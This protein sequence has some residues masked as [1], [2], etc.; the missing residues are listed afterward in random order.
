MGCGVGA[1]CVAGVAQAAS[2]I[3]IKEMTRVIFIHDFDSL[4]LFKLV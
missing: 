3:A 1:A 4:I 2:K